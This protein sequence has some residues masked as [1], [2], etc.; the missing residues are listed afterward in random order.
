VTI[1]LYTICWNE[2]AMLGFFFRHYDA[3]VDRYVIYDDGSTDA[4]LAILHGHPKVEVRRFERVVPDSY[5]ASA[6]HL[7]NSTWKESRDRADWVIITAIDEHL[8]HA[9]LAAYLQRCKASGVTLIP[10]VGYQMVSM[11]FPDPDETL[12]VTR[13][14]G[15]PFAKMNKLSIFDPT[16][17]EEANY[18][19]G[20][21]VARPVGRVSYPERDE[22]LNLHYKY[23][24]ID[25]LK[26]RSQLLKTGLGALDRERRW[27][28]E[29]DSSEAEL[30][31]QFDRFRETAVDIAD[32]ARDPANEG[33]VKKW[34]RPR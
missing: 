6:Q 23:L 33:V 13:T 24:G 3:L 9:N 19:S 12:A 34:W 27:G 25:Y 14:I 28:H 29:Y 15:A 31:Q 32:P 1:D 17:I 16:A 30:R 2:E 22:V 20:R 7:H 18:G 26:Q 8:K 5:V 4:T 10:V 11:G 21:H